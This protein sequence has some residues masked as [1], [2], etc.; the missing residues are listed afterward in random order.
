M[1]GKYDTPRTPTH[2]GFVGFDVLL[3]I[4]ADAILVGTHH[5]R[6]QL[7]EDLESSLVAGQP[8]LSLELDGRH[9]GCL[10]GDKEG[11]PKPDRERR[12]RTLHD[13]AGG[14]TGVT[15]AMATP[16]NTWTIGKAVRLAEIRKS[17]L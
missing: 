9:T 10:A 4:A 3:R 6:A 14:K 7:M 16:Q 11:R 12:V 17:G 13:G 2:P 5:T 15:V 8:E 1:H